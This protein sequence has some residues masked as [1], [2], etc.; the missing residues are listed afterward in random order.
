[1][2]LVAIAIA[3]FTQAEFIGKQYG[4]PPHPGLCCQNYYN[5]VACGI[6]A[7]VKLA[8][9]SVYKNIQIFYFKKPQRPLPGVYLFIFMSLH[10]VLS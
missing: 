3:E 2:E 4:Q 5:P 9:R 7:A 10:R 6:I 8:K 1:V